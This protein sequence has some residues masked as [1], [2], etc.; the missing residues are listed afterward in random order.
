MQRRTMDFDRHVSRR[1]QAFENNPINRVSCLQFLKSEK[2]KLFPAALRTYLLLPLLRQA[3]ETCSLHRYLDVI[4]QWLLCAM[5]R[6][7]C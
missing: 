2:L 4:R 3:L 5:A 1:R 6:K 7:P